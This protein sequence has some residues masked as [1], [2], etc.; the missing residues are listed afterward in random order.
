MSRNRDC[1]SYKRKSIRLGAEI[2]QATAKVCC[3]R[4]GHPAVDPM[5]KAHDTLS[6]GKGI[7]DVGL[8]MGRVADFEHHPHQLFVGA[9]VQRPFERADGR[10]DRRDHIGKRRSVTRAANVDALKPCSAI[11]SIAKSIVLACRS[12]G[13]SPWTMYRK[14]AA[15]SG[16]GEDERAADCA[17]RDSARPRSWEVWQRGRPPAA[18]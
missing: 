10:C 17:V 4:V 9:P 15:W 18:R 6:A 8:H 2:E 13:S 7:V 3:A 1:H 11:R 16:R 12:V 14:L 5:A